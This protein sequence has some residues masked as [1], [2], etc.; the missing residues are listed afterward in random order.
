MAEHEIRFDDG[1]A[2]ERMM[3]AGAGSPASLPRLAGATPR[4][5]MARRR[6]RQRRLHRT[7]R[8]AL[9]ARSAGHRSVGGAAR[10][11]AQAA[12]GAAGGIPPGRRHGAALRRRQLRCRRHGAGDLLRARSGQGRRRDGAG[13]CAR[14][15]G[16]GLCLGRARRRISAGAAAGEMRAMGVTTAPPPSPD[17]ARLEA[18]RALWTGAGIGGVETR[19]ITV[20]RSFA[21]FEDFWTTACWRRASPRRSP[22]C[23]PPTASS[24]GRGCARA[25][26]RMPPAASP[27]APARMQSRGGWRSSDGAFY[28][29]CCINS[30]C[31]RAMR[32]TPR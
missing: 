29:P 1:A 12:G 5:A 13:G 11:R 25:S 31:R 17:A 3:G 14:A 19:E 28:S 26:P 9:C 6:L 27:T 2:Y 32:K 15:A 18:L 30:P 7:A 21:D 24:S 23:L 10:F 20:R 4:L 22:H 8:R 16:R